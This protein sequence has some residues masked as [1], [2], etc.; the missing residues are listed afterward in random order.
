MS[1]NKGLCFHTFFLD[2]LL[3]KHIYASI[4]FQSLQNLSNKKVSDFETYLLDK[5]LIVS[6]HAWIIFWIK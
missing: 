1:N 2:K 5:L 6:V 3:I 4:M